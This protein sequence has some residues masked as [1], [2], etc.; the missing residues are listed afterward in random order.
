MR[1]TL[2][3]SRRLRMR[4]V[5]GFVHSRAIVPSV[6]LFRKQLS[7]IFEGRHGASVR[8]MPRGINVEKTA[9]LLSAAGVGRQRHRAQDRGFSTI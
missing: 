7:K 1:Q 9:I 2:G 4:I 3:R 6:L 8:L 5:G